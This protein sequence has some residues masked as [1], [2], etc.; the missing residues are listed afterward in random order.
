MQPFFFILSPCVW[1]NNDLL[2]KNYWYDI[3][4]IDQSHNKR[5]VSQFCLYLSYPWTNLN[6]KDGIMVGN[7]KK[8]YHLTLKMYKVT[9]YKIAVSQL[10]YDRFLPNFHRNDDKIVISADRENVSQGYHS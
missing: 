7:V 5:N 6:H 4:I 8:C 2:N 9:I 10:L 1:K 3:D